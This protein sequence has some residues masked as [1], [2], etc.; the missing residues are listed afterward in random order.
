MN[1]SGHR[2]RSLTASL[3]ATVVLTMSAGC[4]QIKRSVPSMERVT[5]VTKVVIREPE[6]WVPLTAAALIGIAGVDREISDWASENTPVFGSQETADNR[7]D[8]IRNL[9]IAGMAA[10][11][12]FAPVPVVDDRNQYRV[13]RFAANAL[14]GIASASVVEF[15]KVTV[16][17]DRPNDR[18]SESFPSGHSGGAFTAAV[19]IEQTLN[20][21]IEKPWLRKSIKVGTTGAASL[22]AWARVEAQEHFPVDVLVSAGFSNLIAKVFYQSLVNDDDQSGVPPIAVEASRKGFMVR[23]DQRF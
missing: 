12:A 8:D 15:G 3:V 4:A 21:T 9:L 1:Q 23:L 6:T 7:S 11:S 13:R 5:D 18:N 17:R 20:E 19:Q 22:V 2:L 14:G 16:R 10:T